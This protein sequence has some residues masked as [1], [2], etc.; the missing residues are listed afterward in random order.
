MGVA[1]LMLFIAP[2]W[3]RIHGNKLRLTAIVVPINIYCDK[4]KRLNTVCRYTIKQNR[5][6]DIW[7]VRN[8]T[9]QSVPFSCWGN[10]IA[11][12]CPRW[13][14]DKIAII[15]YQCF[16][17]HKRCRVFSVA[18]LIAVRNRSQLR[19]AELKNKVTQIL[20]ESNKYQKLPV[21]IFRQPGARYCQR[22][23]GQL[24]RT[25]SHSPAVWT[26][27]SSLMSDAVLS[28]I[29]VTG[30][31]ARKVLMVLQETFCSASWFDVAAIS[32]NG[33]VFVCNVTV[34]RYISIRN[35]R[36][37]NLTLNR[38]CL[39][40]HIGK[41]AIGRSCLSTLSTVSA[42]PVLM[43]SYRRCCGWHR[44]ALLF[45]NNHIVFSL[46]LLSLCVL[47]FLFLSSFLR[48]HLHF[49]LTLIFTSFSY[50]I[51]S[52]RIFFLFSSCFFHFLI[53]LLLHVSFS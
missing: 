40:F 25:L 50:F 49:S 42:C 32:D 11:W 3:S 26:P 53:I 52:N 12:N 8:V 37:W 33:R 47:F 34:T 2:L 13:R 5:G 21:T 24:E 51:F 23:G 19:H 7:A 29:S 45:S 48:L 27:L 35:F 30:R 43:A 46:F 44:T 4:Y 15:L 20:T 6:F 28:R 17:G 9:L 39:L 18:R 36:I 10:K 41:H 22:G 38:V 1:S 31:Q 16:S 14:P